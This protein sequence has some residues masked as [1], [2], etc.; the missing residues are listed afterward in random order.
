LLD[1]IRIV[2]TDALNAG[3]PEGI[4]NR[5]RIR[6]RDGRE[7]SKLVTY[8]HGHA[9]QP[10]SDDGVVAKFRRQAA[11]VISDAT[12]NRLVHLALSLDDLSD[13]SPVLEFET[14]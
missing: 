11:G 3:Y 10:L 9:R 8:P 14:S 13:V 7:L 6:L 5:L 12:A 1:K 4:P 2:E